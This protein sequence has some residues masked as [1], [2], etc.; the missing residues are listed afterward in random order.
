M[1]NHWLTLKDR[2]KNMRNQKLYE[3]LLKLKESNYMQP[4]LLPVKHFENVLF[5][6]LSPYD[7]E[8][9]LD[10]SALVKLFKDLMEHKEDIA[11]TKPVSNDQ[12]FRLF[13]SAPTK[14]ESGMESKT[15]LPYKFSEFMTSLNTYPDKFVIKIPSRMFVYS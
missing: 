12:L 6:S 1:E 9:R 7:F 15:E 4:K 8:L 2:V 10:K 13:G 3:M 5:H 11:L 14:D